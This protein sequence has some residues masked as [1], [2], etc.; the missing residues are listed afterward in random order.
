MPLCATRLRFAAVLVAA[1]ATAQ[2]GWVRATPANRPA[3]RNGHAIAYDLTLNTSVL[4]GGSTNGSFA[5]A[6]DTWAWS[7]TNWSQRAPA[8]SPPARMGHG[9]ASELGLG[10]I[11]MFG[12]R[13]APTNELGDTW[14]YDGV[15][16]TQRQPAHQPSPRLYVQMASET[17]G[18]ILLFGGAT[19]G[20]P[21]ALADTWEWDG[22]DWTQHTPPVSP[23]ARWGNGMTGDLARGR[24]VLWG[25]S[26]SNIVPFNDTWTWNG[27]T[28]SQLATSTAPPAAGFSVQL[29]YDS[30]RDLVVLAGNGQTWLFDGTSW[31]SDPRPGGPSARWWTGVAYDIVRGRTI[32]FGGGTIAVRLGDTWEYEPGLVAGGTPFGAG[33]PGTAGIPLLQPVGSSLPIAGATFDLEL[34]GLPAT[35]TA[36]IAIGFSATQSGGQ[37]LPADLGVIGMPSCT[38]YVSPDILS[39]MPITAGRATLSISLV[40]TS[41]L[42]GLS[43]WNQG[44]AFDAG[45]NLF[46]AVVSNAGAGL[47]GAF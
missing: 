11:V 38:L 27:S 26:D 20:P 37:P 29:A 19:R 4:F 43:F 18:R 15:D 13:N 41:S 16:W 22:N 39:F 47:L 45:A 1:A 40:N 10:R 33:C 44:L 17:S 24:I 28:W 7:G 36:V 32:L 25:G 35:G 14:E 2:S 23:P 46:G 30:A 21:D 3:V 42:I 12:G 31:R 8:H 9:L 34:A 6:N 5:N